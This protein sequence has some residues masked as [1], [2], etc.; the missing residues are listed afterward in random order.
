M[1]ANNETGVIQPVDEIGRIAADTGVFFHIDAV[2]GAGKVPI[3]V[4]KIGCHL[5]SISGH[6]MHAPK[7]VG[8][9][10]VRSGTP[11]ESLL[12]GGSHERRRRAGTENVAGIV[13]LGKAAEL[14][15]H[16]LED[17]TIDRLAGL[18][19]KL[20]TGILRLPGTGVN[21]APLNG[22]SVPR[23]ANTSQHLVRQPGGRGAGDRAGP[24][25]H[26]GQR[27]IGLPLRRDRAEPRA[28]G[29]GPGQDARPRQ[30]ALQHAE[31]GHRSG[32]GLRAASGAGGGGAAAGGVA[33]G[34]RDAGVKQ[35]N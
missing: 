6:K 2:Q 20:E 30:P 23:A 25:G 17:G 5:L 15:M 32:R 1:L 3:D 10:F 33:G 14:A 4:R 24:E 21:G 19:H 31:D 9:M 22:E 18:R 29:D 12:V 11:V 16:S 26:C 28:D 8:A 13:G 35:R 7:G 27:R 34:S